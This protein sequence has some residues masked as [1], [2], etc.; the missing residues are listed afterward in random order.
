[1]TEPSVVSDT[2]IYARGD[3]VVVPFPFA[4]RTATKRR[5]AV[6]LSESE[7]Q[8]A[9]GHVVLGMITSTTSPEWGDDVVFRD[10]GSAGLSRGSRFRPKLVT[11]ADDLVVRRA[12]RLGE[13]DARAV[14]ASVSRILGS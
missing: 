4:D 2:P 5:P 11:L 9:T 10:P 1:M 13:T 7:F 3:V 6:V 14:Q 8:E 12:G